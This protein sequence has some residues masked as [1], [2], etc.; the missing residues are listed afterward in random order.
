MG[1]GRI[2]TALLLSSLWMAFAYT[3]AGAVLY[4]GVTAAL[5]ATPGLLAEGVVNSIV[6]L[7]LLPILR[8]RMPRI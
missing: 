4:G 6:A 8:G 2:V 1:Q 5:A 3:L 7:L